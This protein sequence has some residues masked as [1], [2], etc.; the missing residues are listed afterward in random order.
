MHT[1]EFTVSLAELS[2]TEISV[3]K[4]VKA[5]SLP[6]K[7]PTCAPTHQEHK[8]KSLD[9]EVPKV[10]SSTELDASGVEFK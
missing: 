3:S 5:S 1:S 6:K 2:K 8:V 9:T 4:I 7:F 10:E